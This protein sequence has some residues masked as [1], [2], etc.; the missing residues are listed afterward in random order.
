MSQTLK[1]KKEIKKVCKTCGGKGYLKGGAPT[2]AMC[3]CPDCDTPLSP[4]IAYGVCRSCQKQVND[5]QSQTNED[6]EFI[7]RLKSLSYISGTGE[8]WRR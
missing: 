4:D 1:G 2:Y 8:K 7:S 3:A 6:K 5:F